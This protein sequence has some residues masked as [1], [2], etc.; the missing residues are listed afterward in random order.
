MSEE[1]PPWLNAEV[2]NG[3]IR[4]EHSSR[5]NCKITG[6]HACADCGLNEDNKEQR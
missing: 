5:E 2:W 4:V 6:W 3:E 1:K